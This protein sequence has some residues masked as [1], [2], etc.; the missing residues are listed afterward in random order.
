[1]GAAASA[2]TSERSLKL[3][4]GIR[5]Y[6]SSYLQ[7]NLLTLPKLPTA[8][9]LRRIRE[10]K[11]REAWERIKELERQREL[12]RQQEAAQLQL[13][14]GVA[15]SSKGD[16]GEEVLDGGSINIDTQDSPMKVGTR[17][18]AGSE[19]RRFEKLLDFSTRVVNFKKSG[20]GGT[21]GLPIPKFKRGN[22]GSGWMCDPMATGSVDSQE[23]PF[24]LQKQ[25]LLVYIRQARKAKRMDEV[26]ALEASLRD[27]E[28]AMRDRQLS[29][30]S[31]G[32]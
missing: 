18:G 29:S 25:Q 2:D 21:A 19:K 13:G 9:N 15:W 24:V 30:L 3:C 1:M 6:A 11:E 23:D 20:E 27:I 7:D 14:A 12:Q 8:E 17:P 10:Q 26:E 5:I 4:R 32:F 16:E 22:S 31:Y 28:I